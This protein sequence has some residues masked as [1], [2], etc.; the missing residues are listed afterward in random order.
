MADEINPVE[1]PEHIQVQT[2]EAEKE[3]PVTGRIEI[4]ELDKRMEELGS[5]LTELNARFKAEKRVATFDEQWQTHGSRRVANPDSVAKYTDL[6][7]DDWRDKPPV[8]LFGGWSVGKNSLRETARVFFEDGRRVL[9]TDSSRYERSTTGAVGRIR[10]LKEAVVRINTRMIA[11]ADKKR[12]AG[13][14]ATAATWNEEYSRLKTAVARS[15]NKLKAATTGI[16]SRAKAARAERR[17]QT[18]TLDKDIHPVIAG[19]VESLLSIIEDGQLEKAEIVTHSA[20]ALPAVIAASRHPERFSK[21]V[22][23]MPAGTFE[24]SVQDLLRRYLPKLGRSLTKDTLDNPRT[25]TSIN[26]GGLAYILKRPLRSYREIEAI[27]GTKIKKSLAELS[28]RED[29]K[30]AIMQA[31][32]DPLFPP[33][34]IENNLLGR[35]R[36]SRGRFRGGSELM[37][38]AYASVNNRRAGHDDLM[39][40]PENAASGALDILRNM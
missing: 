4:E 22:L 24:D 31:N 12:E 3:T 28:R 20:G 38:D 14:Q 35:T 29:V 23:S 8:V 36:D 34:K 25:G 26:L 17:M 40:N 19:Q 5:R 39:I 32:A 27:T 10:R 16:V 30:V 9:V 13:S 15:G 21:L 11:A 37:V 6:R 18:K 2:P 33:N 1:K 7:P